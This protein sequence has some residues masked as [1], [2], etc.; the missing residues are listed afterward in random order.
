MTFVVPFIGK[1]NYG[2]TK[3]K[4]RKRSITNRIQ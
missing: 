1:D 4:T 3:I 2:K